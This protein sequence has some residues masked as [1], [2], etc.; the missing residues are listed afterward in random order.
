MNVVK[1][2]NQFTTRLH[3]VSITV[4]RTA[5]GLYLAMPSLVIA[6]QYNDITFIEGQRSE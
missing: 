5:N 4:Y 1:H 3:P 6:P 2:T